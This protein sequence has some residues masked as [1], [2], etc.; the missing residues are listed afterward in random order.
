MNN[1]TKLKTQ[2]QAVVH[3]IEQ[4]DIEMVDTLLDDTLEYQDMEKNIFI[5]KLGDAFN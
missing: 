5:N 3:F 1:N 4:L 2:A